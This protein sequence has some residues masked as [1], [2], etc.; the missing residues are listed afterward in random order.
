MLCLTLSHQLE[1]SIP[2]ASA[3]LKISKDHPAFKKLSATTRS[4][5]KKL[6]KT[7]ELANIH[8]KWFMQPIPPENV[9]VGL[10][11]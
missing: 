8:H 1:R 9:C 7:G 6:I 11:L 3:P 2:S 4:T 5:V 10:P